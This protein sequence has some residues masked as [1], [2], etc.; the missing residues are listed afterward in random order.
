MLAPA[1]GVTDSITRQIARRHGADACITEL[2]ASEGLI[3]NCSKTKALMEFD[4]SE[5]PL[6]IQLFGARPDNMARAAE[7]ASELE[8]DFIDLNFV[9]LHPV[10]EFFLDQV[11]VVAK[12]LEGDG[13]TFWIGDGLRAPSQAL[14]GIL[15]IFFNRC[16][17]NNRSLQLEGFEGL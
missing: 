10:F 14:D 12:D 11:P 16:S 13:S 4:D 9:G 1:A 17:F 8:P 3:R 7:I 15:S 5:R 2:I 6:G